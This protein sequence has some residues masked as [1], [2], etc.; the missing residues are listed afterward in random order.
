MKS[1]GL[2]LSNSDI[3]S[4][5]ESVHAGAAFPHECNIGSVFFLDRNIT[6]YLS[7]YYVFNGTQW[8][9]LHGQSDNIVTGHGLTKTI[10]SSASGLSA[11]GLSASGL[12]ASGL[13][14]SD[15]TLSIAPSGATPGTY[16]KV[17]VGIDGRVTS[18]LELSPSDISTALG[19]TPLDTSTSIT[20]DAILVNGVFTIGQTS[21]LSTTISFTGSELFQIDSFPITSFRSVKYNV[22]ISDI[23]NNKFHSVEFNI[24][25]DGIDVF[26]TEFA[27][28]STAGPLGDFDANINAGSMNITFLPNQ[29]SSYS[30]K[31]TKFEISV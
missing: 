12:S 16:S 23:Q 31:L 27:L 8:T 18:G 6:N 3:N 15:I 20:S 28:I 26:K 9:A 29:Y 14:A 19:F 5:A 24:I 17:T 1:Y 13:S 7:G 10:S 4:V 21:F 11:S 25:H 30:A 22:Q 2:D